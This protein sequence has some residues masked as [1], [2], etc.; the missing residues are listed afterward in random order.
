LA[1]DRDSGFAVRPQA[2][3]VNT[4]LSAYRFSEVEGALVTV[5]HPGSHQEMNI[6]P[7]RDS[8]FLHKVKFSPARDG[9]GSLINDCAKQPARSVI[10]HPDAIGGNP[11][12]HQN[13][14]GRH[15]VILMTVIGGPY[16]GGSSVGKPQSHRRPDRYPE[17][18]GRDCPAVERNCH[19]TAS[20]RPGIGLSRP[21]NRWRPFNAT[22]LGQRT[23]LAND[24]VAGPTDLMVL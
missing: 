3:R 1:P 20:S 16:G 17:S 13:C 11:A 14:S 10:K 23:E 22:E 6:L 24:M 19:A 9:S 7:G 18:E 5:D 15:D 12:V 2:H 4:K 8:K 21:D